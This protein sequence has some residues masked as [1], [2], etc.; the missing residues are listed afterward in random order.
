MLAGSL[1]NGTAHV[2]DAKGEEP[3][4][5][6]AWGWRQKEIGAG[7]NYRLEWQPQGRRIGWLDK[8]G[9]FLEQEAAFAA[10][11]DM[12][13]RTNDPL[14]IGSRTLARRLDERQLLV[15]ADRA[16]KRLTVFRDLEG[17]RRYVLH[18]PLDVFAEGLLTSRTDTLTQVTQQSTIP[19]WSAVPE[20]AK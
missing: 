12:G 9:L 16:R 6:K 15:S 20:M 7:D 13:T 19:I 10:A 8:D 11:Q 3:A 1:A 18:L 17:T 4:G 14:A 5:A 2:A